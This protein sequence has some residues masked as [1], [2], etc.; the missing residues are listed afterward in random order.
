MRRK[1]KNMRK[2]FA[3]LG[4]VCSLTVSL[5]MGVVISAAAQVPAPTPVPIATQQ[6]VVQ[7]SDPNAVAFTTLGQSEI[8]LTSPYD[9]ATF[10]FALPADW[11]LTTGAALNLAMSVS[12]SATGQVASSTPA[13]VL[14]SLTTSGGTLSVYFNA[15]QLGVIQLNQVGEV[16]ENLTIPSNALISPNSDG[17][18]VLTLTLD[19]SYACTVNQETIVSIH[20]SSQFLLPH[21]SEALTTS[22]ANFP[23]PIYQ[24]SFIPDSAVIV[25]PDHPSSTD[26]QDAMTVAAGLGN[27]S[28]NALLLDMT[29]ASQLNANQKSAN[30]LIFVGKAATSLSILGSLPLPVP[31]SKGQFQ[32]TGSARRWIDRND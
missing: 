11:K 32:L 30:H 1:G 8:Q 16:Q 20:T 9:T 6:P 15:V 27:M 24:G 7:A 12:F 26:L 19:S 31:V 23:Q 10:S 21:K 17:R 28:S 5:I 22:L 14:N 3:N 2:I 4:L 13:P 25:V 29:T 18:M